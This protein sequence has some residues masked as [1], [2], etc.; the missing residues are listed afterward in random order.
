MLITRSHMRITGRMLADQRQE[1]TSEVASVVAT[2]DTK[3]LRYQKT[4]VSLFSILFD[5]AVCLIKS[6]LTSFRQIGNSLLLLF[7]CYAY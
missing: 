1:K 3:K 2:K 4:A 5:N 7:L 6:K